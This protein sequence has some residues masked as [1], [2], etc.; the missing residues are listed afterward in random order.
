MVTLTKLFVIKTVVN[1]SS[2]SESNLLTFSSAEC[3]P[4]FISFRFAGVK[5]KKA[6]SDPEAKAETNNS[7]IAI[8][9]AIIA[10]IEGALIVIAS[11]SPVQKHK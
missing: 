6:I 7:N 4:S 1:N 9:I 8:I 10:D 2:E 11:V 5:E 3:L